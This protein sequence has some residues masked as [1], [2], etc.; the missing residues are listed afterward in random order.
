MFVVRLPRRIAPLLALASAACGSP[1]APDSGWT[2]VSEHTACEALAPQYCTG[3]FGFAVQEDGRFTVG[4]SDSGATLTGTITAVERSRISSDAAL[5][6]A[7]L[8]MTALCDEA[9]TIPGVG[10]R[11]DLTD[12]RA[13]TIPVY[14]AGLGGVCY[15]AGRDQAVKLHAD[16]SAL[17]A[18]YYPRPFPAL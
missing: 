5:V 10:D 11:V 9:H 17:M 14:E 13:G 2:Q 15:R 3:A 12:T 8:T 18:K 6:S 1:S 16:L 7:S 4:P